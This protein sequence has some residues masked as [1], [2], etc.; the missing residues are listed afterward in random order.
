VWDQVQDEVQ[1]A[2]GPNS[3]PIGNPR[4]ILPRR[5]LI[6]INGAG[7]PAAI[8]GFMICTLPAG[9]CSNLFSHAS[10]RQSFVAAIALFTLFFAAPFAS[11]EPPETTFHALVFSKTTGFRHDSI[12]DGIAAIKKLG[13]EHRFTIFATEDSSHFTPEN[14]ARY[15]VVIFLNTSGDVLNEDQ[16]SAF[17]N[18]IHSGGGLA[19]VHAAIPG[20]VATEGNWAWYD[21][22][23]CA[24]FTNHSAIV[25]ATIDVEDAK[26]PST[27]HLPKRWSRIDEW[28]N[29]IEN[30]RGKVRVL[31]TLDES[32]YQGGTMGEDHPISWAKAAGKGRL[33]YTALGHT[34]ESYSEP[35]FLQHLLGGIQAAAGVEPAE[36]T[37]NARAGQG[38]Q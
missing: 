14:L 17:E 31:A 35:L 9:S 18:Y 10:I 33:W 29:F 12:P 19:G 37:P 1:P 21:E 30:P 8:F 4:Y 22:S 16:Q 13:E 7:L 26:H 24:R 6:L 27:R 23:F 25:R 34:K 3:V 32:T 38:K 28:Y 2:R 11:A 36:F 5:P 20:D 15:R